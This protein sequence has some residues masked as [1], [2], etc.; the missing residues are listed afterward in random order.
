ML[1]Y[2]VACYNIKHDMTWHMCVIRRKVVIQTEPA[3][4]GTLI[5]AKRVPEYLHTLEMATSD[6]EIVLWY[7]LCR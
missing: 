3:E 6:E 4:L 5:G 2:T 7:E 1:D